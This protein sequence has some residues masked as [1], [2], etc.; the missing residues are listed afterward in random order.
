MA[1]SVFEDTTARLCCH[2]AQRLLTLMSVPQLPA[3][4][5]EFTTFSWPALLNRLRQMLAT[6]ALVCGV[7]L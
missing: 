6:G 3:R 1:A 4:S 5:A 2:P 7:L